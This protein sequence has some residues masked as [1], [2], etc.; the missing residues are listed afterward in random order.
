MSLMLSVLVLAGSASVVAAGADPSKPK[1]K[2]SSFA[3][4][5]SGKRVYGTPIQRPILH[6]R[7]KA[8]HKAP[9]SGLAS[10]QP[11]DNGAR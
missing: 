8:S 9:K 4:H 10:R 1:S 3:P 5:H 2:P 6:K 7:S 11:L